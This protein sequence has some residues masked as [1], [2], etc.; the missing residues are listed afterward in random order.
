[1]PMGFWDRNST[2]MEGVAEVVRALL[3]GFLLAA[4]P[5]NSDSLR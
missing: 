5:V 2:V 4:R 1:M 3:V